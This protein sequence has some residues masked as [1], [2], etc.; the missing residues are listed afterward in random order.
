MSRVNDTGH[1]KGRLRPL[2][3]IRARRFRVLSTME[4][5]FTCGKLCPFLTLVR[6]PFWPRFFTKLNCVVPVGLGFLSFTLF[7]LIGRL[8]NRV[9]PILHLFAC[10]LWS[11]WG[12]K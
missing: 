11:L 8:L 5:L 2:E 6:G 1:V 4:D 10:S 7:L 3:K 12:F 9:L